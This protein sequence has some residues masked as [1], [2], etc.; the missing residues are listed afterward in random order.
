MGVAGGLEPFG[1]AYSYRQMGGEIVA[2]RPLLV[3][4]NRGLD[5][6]NS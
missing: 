4:G 2:V 3:D 6:L 5:G 1:N